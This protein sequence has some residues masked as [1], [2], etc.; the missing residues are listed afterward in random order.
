MKNRMLVV[1]LAGLTLLSGCALLKKAASKAPEKWGVIA[2]VGGLDRITQH[3]VACLLKSYNINCVIEG[4]AVYSVSVPVKDIKRGIGILKNDLKFRIYNITLCDGDS[5]RRYS[6][7][8]E[9]WKIEK[10]AGKYDELISLWEYRDSTVLGAVLRQ[11]AIKRDV[12]AFPFVSKTRIF[13]REYFG[14]QSRINTGY[15]VE[16]ELAASLKEDIGGK[17]LCFQVWDDGRQVQTLGSNEWWRGNRETVA[18]NQ[19]KYDKR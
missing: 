15:E 2:T 9:K 16:I 1:L 19:K 3:H 10:M 8:E 5:E 13:A 7:P 6:V 18:A 11:A 17:R 4:S 12:P 14:P